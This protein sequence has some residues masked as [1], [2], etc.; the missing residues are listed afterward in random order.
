MQNPRL[1]ARYAK[2]V[3]DLA[4]EKSQ[5]EN[6]WADMKYLQQVCKSSKDFLSL[7]R[8][9]IIKSDKKQA[10][11]D[12]ISKGKVGVIT[13]GFIRLLVAKSRENVLP[14]IINAFMEQYYELKG[15][16]KIKL[17]TAHPLSDQIKET[18]INKI[19]NET[20][21]GNVELETKVKCELIGGFVLEYNNNLVDA[22]IA[23]DLKDIKKQ[24]VNNEFVKKIR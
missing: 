20:A 14:E 7:L 11:L 2:S 6:V 23:R 4:I 19:K 17:T 13:E 8:S 18:L 24:F 15:I 1:A 9:P 21:M 12:S 10:V 3:I 22:S 16:H 5:L